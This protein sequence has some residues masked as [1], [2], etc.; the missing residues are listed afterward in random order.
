[1]FE[2]AG[3]SRYEVVRRIGAGGMGVVYEAEDKERGQRVA[4]KTI[5]HLD[6]EKVYQLKREFRVLADLSHP[7]LVALYDL[8]VD[9]GTCFFTMELLDGDDLTQHLWSKPDAN[10]GTDPEIAHAHTFKTP[11]PRA[12]ALAVATPVNLTAS[13]DPNPADAPTQASNAIPT[14]CDLIRLRATLPQLARG[15]HALHLAG[16]V[17]RDVKPSNIRVTNDGRVV[18]L[19][20]GLVAELERRAGSGGPPDAGG[21]IVGTVSFMAPEQCAADVSLTPAADWYALG[22]VL[23]HALTGRFPFEGAPARVL[24][25]KQTKTAPRASRYALG[26]PGDLDD[27]CAELLEREPTD[28]PIGAAVLSRLGSSEPSVRTTQSISREASFA[29]RDAELAQL[30]AAFALACGTS[31]PD[32]RRVR[33]SADGGA[34][35]EDRRAAV[36][37]VRAPSGLGKSALVARFLDRVRATREDAVILRGRCLDREDVPYKAIDP[38]VDELSDWWLELPPKEAQSILPRDADL[39]PTLFPVLDR[40]PAIADAP[41]TRQLADP[42]ARRTRAFDALRETLQRLGDR[43]PVVL[44]L[45]DMQWVDRDTTA[46]L[47]DLM[48]APDPPPILLVLAT[49]ADDSTQVVDLVRRMDAHAT[50]IELGPLPEDVAV[51]LACTQ[52]GDDQA[53]VA[54]RLVREADGNPLFVIELTRYLQSRT[55]DEVAGK[56][57][58]AVLVERLDELGESGRV[59]AEIVAVAGEPISRRHLG[60]AA[61]V[62]TSDLSRQLQ[63]LRAQRVVK[64]SGSRADDMI[65]P[66]HDRIRT[67]VMTS[68][69]GDR[70]AKHHRALAAALASKGTAEQLARHWYLAGE[71]DHAAPHARRAGD[72]ARAR[73]DFDTCARW[74]GIA[75]EA[76]RWTDVE[77][78]ELR[79]LYGDALADAGR[80]REAADVFLAAADGA[81]RATALE[82]RRRAS[83]SLLQSGHL[84]EGLALTRSVLAGVGLK[85]ARTPMGSLIQMLLRRAWLRVRG[86]GFRERALSEISQAELTR[87]DVCEGVSFGMVFVNTFR[88]MDFGMRFLLGALRLGETWRVSRGLALETDYLAATA[89]TRRTERL[90]ARLEAMTASLVDAHPAARSQLVTTRALVEFFLHNRFDLASQLFADAIADYRAVVGRA[91]FELD[92]VLMFE[93]WALYYRGEIGEL[94]RRVPAM[95]EEAARNGNQYTALTMHSAFPLAWLARLEPD[96]VEASV[97]HAVG[98]WSTPDQ[99]CQLQHLF[100]LCS[101]VDLAIY[102]GD[103]GS[104]GERI[105]RDLPPIRRALLDVPPIQALLLRTTLARQ[106][107][108]V[109]AAAPRE[110]SAQRAALASARKH[111][112]GFARSPLP[113][114]RH[115]QRLFAALGAEIAGRT[116]VAM[117]EYRACLPLFDDCGAHIYAHA[118][119]DRLGRLVGGDAGAA[120][121]R[122]TAD[123]LARQGVRDSERTLHM[124]LPGAA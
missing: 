21:L 116:D 120:L 51:A 84:T 99:L 63:Q 20:F 98:S 123:W 53:D 14:P 48:R 61:G 67:A 11:D 25:E 110:S 96:A 59:L 81:D 65:E 15:L 47:A 124:L 62:A 23:F 45:D 109:A 43:R 29:G 108:A 76:A 80:P 12:L 18:L 93:L 50:I 36:A 72:E 91:G 7:N 97:D 1:V 92:T 42:Q 32:D 52:L 37:V 77:R 115:S 85:M 19:D 9:A 44:F 4:L 89:K 46:L 112:R 113:L 100:A 90:L 119:R 106:Q 64:T 95:A 27:L 33:S 83:A 8:V 38:L 88:A 86:L 40:V 16:K 5:T 105:A 68:M 26:V 56:G 114:Q 70:R 66:Y 31:K 122:E 2:I 103:A 73:L 71:P 22:V 6:V 69:A 104:V 39:L 3:S 60:T 74:Y 121:R 87:V 34:Q 55:L 24:L 107:L 17:H 102:R 79:S 118:A 35:L 58:D 111:L 82:L 94:S 30:D 75:L 78:R 54:R 57:L 28:R 10:R 13:S 101:H 41:R 49:R 117:A